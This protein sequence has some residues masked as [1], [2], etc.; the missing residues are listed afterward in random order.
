MP[1]TQTVNIMTSPLFC[2]S[3]LESGS[4]NQAFPHDHASWT[5]ALSST[6]Q[7]RCSA[8]AGWVSVKLDPVD[9]TTWQEEAHWMS[10]HHAVQSLVVSCQSMERISAARGHRQN[11]HGKSS[12]HASSRN[13][14]KSLFA[15]SPNAS[16]KST[17]FTGDGSSLAHSVTRQLLAQAANVPLKTVHVSLEDSKS[18]TDIALE[19]AEQDEWEVTAGSPSS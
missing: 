14:R 9:E 17:D 13:L 4:H 16:Q 18:N 11:T 5:S 10:F 15:D 7:S 12:R 3:S 8:D 6:V 2:S 19:Q 1:P